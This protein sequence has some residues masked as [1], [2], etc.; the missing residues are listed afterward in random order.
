MRDTLLKAFILTLIMVAITGW[1]TAYYRGNIINEQ[2]SRIAMLQANNEILI[3]GRKNDYENKVEL[4]ERIEKLES[5]GRNDTGCFTWN[6]DISNH[7]II[8]Q[9]RKDRDPIR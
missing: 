3:K 7:P 1:F 9:L 4:A 5:L 2:D 6:D 8:M